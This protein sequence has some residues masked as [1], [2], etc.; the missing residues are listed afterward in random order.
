MVKISKKQTD[1]LVRSV[2]RSNEIIQSYDD[3]KKLRENFTGK[4]VTN[5]FRVTWT[6]MK[7]SEV[8]KVKK[9]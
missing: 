1:F 7:E 6:E 4:P 3:F 9:E 8:R 5:R 2:L